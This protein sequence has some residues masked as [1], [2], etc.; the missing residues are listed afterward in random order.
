MMDNGRCK[1][2]RGVTPAHILG[3]MSVNLLAF[4]TVYFKVG[5]QHD[6]MNERVKAIIDLN[7]KS[8]PEG[9]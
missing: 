5:L 8:S 2:N 6:C 9:V 7:V 3:E 4:H 1:P